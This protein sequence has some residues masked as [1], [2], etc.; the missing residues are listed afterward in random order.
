MTSNGTSNRDAGTIQLRRRL[1]SGFSATMD[2]TYSKSMDDAAPGG[3]QTGAVFIAQDWRNL[4]AERA[5]SNFD[6]RH[7]LNIS[8]QFTSGMG[9]GGGTLMKG[10]KAALLK[11]WTFSGQLNAASGYPLTPVYP[12]AVLGTGVTGSVRPDYT[13][14]SIKLA[15]PGL[16]LNPAAYAAPATGHWGNAGRNSIPGP[17]QFGLNASLARTFRTSGRTSLDL[18]VDANNVLNH[19]TFPSWDTTVGS[20]QFGL[21]IVANSMRNVQTAIRWTF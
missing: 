6:R 8:F 18:R 17:S 5:L 20:A 16:H 7:Q 21:P 3:N 15:P 11:E 14:A 19:V 9:I 1:R 10:W 13:G 12:S 2:Y 4:G